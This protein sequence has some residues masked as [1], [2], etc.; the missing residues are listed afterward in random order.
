MKRGPTITAEDLLITDQLYRRLPRSADLE[1]ELAA[2]RELSALMAVDPVQAINRF[3]DLALELCPAAGSAGL[4]ELTMADS[5]D[6]VFTWTAMSGAFAQ[7]VGGTTPRNF[8]PC[9]LCL[10]HHHTVLVDRPGRLFS[11][12][13]EAEPEIVEGLIVPLYDTGKRPI[14]TLWVTSHEDGRPFDPTDARVMEQLAVQLVLAIKLRRKAALYSKLEEAMRDKD[15]LVHEVRHRVK[16]MIQMTSALL[17]LQERGVQSGE[18]RSALR[19]AQS[20]LLV[21]ASVYEALLLPEADARRV[22]VAQLIQSLATALSTTSPQGDEVKI[23]T[24]CDQALLGVSH[25]VP[26]G[27]IVNE[28]ITNALKHAFEGRT[29]GRVDISLRK[30]G[31]QCVL[32]VSDDGCG[33]DGPV[34][35]GSLGMRLM[36]SLARQVG[37]RISV[38]GASGTTVRLEWSSEEDE[39]IRTDVSLGALQN[40]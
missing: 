4:S 37:G 39:A 36:K 24:D 29:S 17:V 16:N 19:E 13:N 7:Y 11:Y 23:T 8:S 15:V 3:L 22:D 14:G 18:A 5:S 33:F 1:T 21:L 6:A 25:A 20:R 35:A 2:Y 12:F 38:D 40:A 27:L 32:V 9:G 34:R 28:A 30:S 10:D 26:V 31:P